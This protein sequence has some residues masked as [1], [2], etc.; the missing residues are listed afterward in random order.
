MFSRFLFAAFGWTE[1][2]TTY[3]TN[4]LRNLDDT[5]R[6][7]SIALT[8]DLITFSGQRSKVNVTVGRRSGEGI[9][10]DAGPLLGRRR[11]SSSYLKKIVKVEKNTNKKFNKKLSIKTRVEYYF[12][13]LLK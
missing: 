11:L 12:R 4:G 5:Y 3:L 10:V 2:V 9:H 8:D 1:L 7:Y 6:K 13:G